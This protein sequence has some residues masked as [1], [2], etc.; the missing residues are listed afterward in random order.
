[1]KNLY[2]VNVVRPGIVYVEAENEESAERIAKRVP[3][4]RVEW[5][6]YFEQEVEVRDVFEFANSSEYEV[7]ERL[8]RPELCDYFLY[9]GPVHDGEQWK[10]AEIRRY[11]GSQKCRVEKTDYAEPHIKPAAQ[12]LYGLMEDFFLDGLYNGGSEFKLWCEDSIGSEEQQRLLDKLA[13]HVNAI[14]D[15]LFE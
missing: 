3:I 12:R 2:E 15:L 1:M 14:A 5:G 6:K 9:R 7:V 10:C 4:D 11:L 8:I 13:E